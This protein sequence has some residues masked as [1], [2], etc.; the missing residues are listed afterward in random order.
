MPYTMVFHP[1]GIVVEIV[2]TEAGDQ[3]HSCEEHPAN[4]GEVLEPDVVVRLL[5]VQLMVEGREEMAI[6]AVWVTDRIDRCR[7]GFLKR[8][9][10][11]HAACYDGSLAQV[12]RVFS[13]DP[14][15]CDLAEWRMHHHN[16]GCCLATIISCLPVVSCVNGEAGKDLTAKLARRWQR[17]SVSINRMN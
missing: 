16:R 8:H 13:A 5:K 4:C 1:P 6:A 7:V 9:M 12:T 15:C 14:T 10:V 3:G 11:K 17:G 2:G